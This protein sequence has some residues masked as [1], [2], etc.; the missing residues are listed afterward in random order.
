MEYGEGALITKR[1]SNEQVL[2]DM[3]HSLKGG[4]WID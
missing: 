4:F 1:P 2:T 3:G